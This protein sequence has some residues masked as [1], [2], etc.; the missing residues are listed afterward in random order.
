MANEARTR[1]PQRVV[2]IGASA[3]GL[4]ALRQLVG[5]LPR[6]S[7]L[8]F[9]ILQHLPPGQTGLLA[10]L[11][12][13][14][15]PL[16][17]VDVTSGHRIEPN[18]ILV[19]PAHTSAALSHGA[20]VL[21]TAKAGTRPELPID[22]LFAS[23]AAVLRENAVGVVLSGT[24]S[25][26]TEGLRAIHAAG[27]LTFAQDPATAQFDDMP[28]AA[29]TAGV[30]QTVLSPAEI[31]AALGALGTPPE[32]VAE[33]PGLEHVLEQLREASGVD[34]SSYKRSTIERRL[35]RRLAK[36]QLSS[37]EAYSAFLVANPEEARS[38]YEDLLI[39]VTEFFRDGPML[40]MLV[41]RLA[42]GGDVA[43]RV[44]VPGCSTGEEVYSLAML[45]V[46]RFG[47]RR[48]VQLFGS[49]L[50]EHAID[51]ARI[52]RYPESV[53]AQV[54]AERLARFFKRDGDGYRI[55]REIRERCI[56]AR[57]D[58]VTDP[59]FSRLD[60][61]SCRN[62]LIYL[63][64]SLQRRVIPLFHY[65]LNQPG[66]LLL[67][68]AESIGDLEDLFATVDGDAR[69]FA[70]KPA[71][72]PVLTFPL[73]GQ[74][75]RLPLRSSASS[76]YTPLQLQ[77]E[78]D[79]ILLAR[80][81]PPCVVVDERLDII[82]FR[83]RTG[84]YLEPPPGHPEH[85][86]LRMARPGLASELPLAVQS[87]RR[88]DLPVRRANLAIGDHRFDLEV[89]PLRATDHAARHFLILFEAVV[90]PL[91]AKLTN[92]A[93]A[94]SILDD[95]ELERLRQE[96]SATKE[97][98]H[99]V[100]TQHLATTEDLGV[101]NE[102]LQSTNE[103]LQSSNE[104]L[105]TAKEELQSS[106]EELETVNEELAIGNARLGEVNDDLANVLASVE[107]A[108]IMVD[109]ERRIRRFT[110]RARAVMKLIAGDIGRPIADLKPTVE[111][112][113]LD[114]AIAKVIETLVLHESEVRDP[115]GAC[116]RM[117]I[118]PYR[119]S[120]DQIRGA[121]ITF[122]DITALR[123]AHDY[124]TAI[125]ETVPTPIVVLDDRLRI[126]SANPAFY[127]GAQPDWSAPSLRARLDE[128]VATGTG[129]DDLEVSRAERLLRLGARLIPGS[130]SL[131]VG[132]ADITERRRL[133]RAR[134]AFLDAVSHELRTPLA[135]ILLWAQALRSLPADDPRRA[136][137]IETI[138]ECV[139]VEARLVDDLIEVASSRSGHLN[140]ELESIDPCPVIEAAVAALRSDADAKQIAVDVVCV[141]SAPIGVDPRR[142]RQIAVSLISNAIKFTPVGGHV[143]IELVRD[144]V[145]MELR[146]RDT[147]PGIAPELLATVFEPF[148]QG[149]DSRTRAH[150][151]LG[152][153]L[154]L[155]RHL[156]ERH[157]G[158]IVA[159]SPGYGHGTTVTVRIPASSIST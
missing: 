88:D 129:F 144:G 14:T 122:V 119:T 5:K 94:P 125:I 48:E 6:D 39:H 23:L 91:A 149:D 71:S 12:A 4:D 22:G 123:A 29:I 114:A 60:A 62:V 16:P 110:P 77:H 102:E 139:G 8:A 76:V 141:P 116:Y 1:A 89:V 155:A 132:I 130:R 70:R 142:L 85:N 133:E 79:Q 126:E 57:H 42:P 150:R 101:A 131:L 30:V 3:G 120:G 107:I 137:A 104:E 136:G 103:E 66:F 143:W 18:T 69:L 10:G 38:V 108:I 72:R 134:G 53:A 2:G 31:G 32:R 55:N 15:T 111:A 146:V 50:S 158:T 49:D 17:V 74:L 41:G 65:A 64:G 100:V 151:G 80:Y 44:W 40:E 145:G 59:P 56:F 75:G 78:I 121:V 33:P 24:Q 73:A 105:Q 63:D 96:L 157:Q 81:S 46:E 36:H 140:V 147:G 20:L 54:G 154:A 138:V 13:S 117:Q 118:R 128:V 135:A 19:V 9:V 87:A 27:G 84:A 148:S 21:H 51:C 99:V 86:L 25:D 109:I 112:P 47:E 124:A 83:G 93:A 152:I 26:G 37:L 43:V 52:G 34:F 28:R 58:L 159:S 97:Y 127:A 95:R 106:N 90:A 67:G 35:A 61:V 7:G 98:L 153:G 156:V 45:L 11:L 82:Q 68:R 92:G 115:D 113:G